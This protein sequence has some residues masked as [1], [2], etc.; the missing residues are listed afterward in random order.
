MSRTNTPPTE[1]WLLNELAAARG[2]LAEIERE[3]GMAQ[4][5]AARLEVCLRRQQSLCQSFE[6]VLEMT[7]GEAHRA[8][9]AQVGAHRPYGG[10]GS[11]RQWLRETI[12]AEYPRSL[13]SVTLLDRAIPVF[14]LVFVSKADRKRYCDN[15]FRRQLASLLE[16][17]FVE[18][19]PLA[20]RGA[21]RT[22][23]RWKAPA[24]LNSVRVQAESAEAA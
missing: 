4:A 23:W 11:L 17:G 13:D 20:G 6:K 21:V 5:A 24:D 19:L 14:G 3:L 8:W 16:Q 12:Q 7:I 9:T 22:G 2:E 15:T 18:R 10:R 1:K